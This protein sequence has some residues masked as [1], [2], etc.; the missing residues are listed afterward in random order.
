MRPATLIIPIALAGVGI[1]LAGCSP[2]P[3]HDPNLF[4]NTRAATETITLAQARAFLASQSPGDASRRFDVVGGE[5]LGRTVILKTRAGDDA[6]VLLRRTLL[7]S[8]H[9]E[10][11]QRFSI[12]GG[13]LVSTRSTNYDRDV[14]TEFHP[15]LLIFPNQLAPGSPATQ[16]LEFIVRPLGDPRRIKRRGDASVT[17]S[18]VDRQDVALPGGTADALHVRTVLEIDFGAAKVERTTDQWFLPGAGLVAESFDER[19]KVLGVPTE[20]SRQTMR[21]AEIPP[22]SVDRN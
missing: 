6:D 17:I 3:T 10:T 5:P 21:A 7:G 4:T 20:R 18:L 2:G 13:A 22:S 9:P 16:S 15:P 19:I 8:A 11:V 1:P 14:I 12:S